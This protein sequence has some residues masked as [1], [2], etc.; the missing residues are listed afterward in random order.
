[1]NEKDLKERVQE[2]LDSPTGKSIKTLIAFTV[3]K[4]KTV[5]R[6]KSKIL[7]GFVNCL[8]NLLVTIFLLRRT[9]NH[10]TTTIKARGNT[11]SFVKTPNRRNIHIHR[12]FFKLLLFCRYLTKKYILAVHRNIAKLS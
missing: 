9:T 8:K 11:A 1:M 3:K 12:E 10:I 5:K 4:T 2:F 7:N 6:S